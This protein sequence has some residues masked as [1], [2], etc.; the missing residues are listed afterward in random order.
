MFPS[1]SFD[2]DASNSTFSGVKPSVTDAVK[3]ELGA[4]FGV[5]AGAGADEPPPPPQPVLSTIS[6]ASAVM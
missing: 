3:D 2:A 4:W 6:E 5:T 1:L